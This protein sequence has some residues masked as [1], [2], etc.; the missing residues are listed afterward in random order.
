VTEQSRE[1]VL[2]RRIARLEYAIR[3]VFKFAACL[4]P[5]PHDRCGHQ[6]SRVLSHHEFQDV[7]RAYVEPLLGLISDEAQFFRG[8]TA[9]APKEDF[10]SRELTDDVRKGLAA[11]IRN[12]PKCR[13]Y[14]CKPTI[15]LT[16]WTEFDDHCSVCGPVRDWFRETHGIEFEAFT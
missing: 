1:A 7:A 6:S 11:L 12:C 3:E 10:M 13:G 9:P 5:L 2:E 8:E 14:G 16:E 4:G 15:Q